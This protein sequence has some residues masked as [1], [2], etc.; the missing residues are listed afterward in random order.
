MENTATDTDSNTSDR[1]GAES[2]TQPKKVDKLEKEIA[3]QRQLFDL[4]N[5]FGKHIHGI[6]YHTDTFGDISVVPTDNNEWVSETEETCLCSTCRMP[7]DI[8]THK[9]G[10]D[11]ICEFMESNICKDY[12]ATY[13][14][15][16]NVS[17]E[18][19]D[20]LKYDRSERDAARPSKNMLKYRKYINTDLIHKKLI[21]GATKR[22]LAV[23][24]NQSKLIRSLVR[25]E[26]NFLG[27]LTDKTRAA[28]ERIVAPKK[29][30]EQRRAAAEML[31]ASSLSNK[32]QL[33]K[34]LARYVPY[35]RNQTILREYGYKANK[36]MYRNIDLSST[37]A[38]LKSY[39]YMKSSCSK[40]MSNE[41]WVLET[42]RLGCPEYESV[43]IKYVQE[44]GLGVNAGIK[45]YD[46]LDLPVV[47]LIKFGVIDPAKYN[48]ESFIK[49]N[50]TARYIF[51]GSKGRIRAAQKDTL[52]NRVMVLD[53]ATTLKEYLNAIKY[54]ESR[55][56]AEKRTTIKDVLSLEE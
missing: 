2:G 55:S 12:P 6:K 18:K 42:L 41:A 50:S 19:W 33:P 39:E 20:P 4:H 17:A 43:F 14:N 9:C 47:A 45:Y 26:H 13:I 16:V 27:G 36:F 46:D 8:V 48:L 44:Y 1:T 10:P 29:P 54:W 53:A 22:C 40:R 56:T 34:G 32:G 24:Y 7:I 51:G 5:S 28:L 23:D 31:M 3:D 30:T 52:T 21:K 35:I 15:C 37:E 25:F 38:C 11:D 49:N